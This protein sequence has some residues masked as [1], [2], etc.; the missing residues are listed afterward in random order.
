MK[1]DGNE[2]RKDQDPAAE[3]CSCQLKTE[4]TVVFMHL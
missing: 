4:L 1:Q 3:G 2:C